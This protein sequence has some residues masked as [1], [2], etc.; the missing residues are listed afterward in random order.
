M[1][2]EPARLRSTEWA[3]SE[4]FEPITSR[5]IIGVNNLMSIAWLSHGLHLSTSVARI[6]TLGGPGTGFLIGPDLL[7]TNHHVIQE[8][9]VAERAS[10]EFNYQKTWQGTM[11]PVH[12]YT[13]DPAL[14]RTN[15]ELDYSIVRVR[16]A[17]GDRFGYVDLSFHGTPSV[18][19]YVCIIQHPRGG[20]KQ[21]CLTDNKVSAVFGDVVQYTTDT[22][23][24]S[25]GSPVFNQHWELVGLHH[26][27]GGLAGPDG[28]KH[29]TNQGILIT[30]ILRDAASFLGAPDTLY[31]VAFGELR[32]VLVRLVERKHSPDSL[33]R[34]AYDLLRSNPQLSRTLKEW[35]GLRCGSE[36]SLTACV[37]GGGIAIGSALRHWARHEGHEAVEAV[38]MSDPEPPAELYDLTGRFRG[39]DLLPEEVHDEVLAAIGASDLPARVLSQSETMVTGPEQAFL[40][41]VTVGA[42]A[43]DGPPGVR[44]LLRAGR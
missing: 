12:R 2:E 39:A 3:Q 41:G 15:P 6:M 27:G 24:G 19:D 23:P 40:L 34:V 14:F 5:K 32:A 8:E 18:N 35:S 20:P 44:G 38:A 21:V 28:Q 16:E 22:E 1:I 31:N 43:F 30:S 37:C 11:E 4:A 42:A 17:P 13:L 9:A 29:Y 36:Q 26:K 10:V 33:Q 7:I 25:S